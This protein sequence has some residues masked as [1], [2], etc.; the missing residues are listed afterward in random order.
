MNF[1]GVHWFCKFSDVLLVLKG[2]Q[3]F[4]EVVEGF[5]MLLKVVGC[6]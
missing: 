6:V 1:G 5:C 3:M 4:V 2:V